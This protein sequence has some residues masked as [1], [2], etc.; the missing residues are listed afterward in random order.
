MAD[1]NE[2]NGGI[3][4]R[5]LSAERKSRIPSCC[6]GCSERFPFYYAVE[7]GKHFPNSCRKD[8]KISLVSTA[9][10]RR[11]TP[12]P[13]LTPPQATWQRSTAFWS[14]T[15]SGYVSPWAETASPHGTSQHSAATSR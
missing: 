10:T 2:G 6:L 12:F 4:R 13:V 3:L 8:Q 11:L 15:P 7:E 14:M 9:D 5:I 1:L